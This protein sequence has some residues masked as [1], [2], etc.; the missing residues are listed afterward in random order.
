MTKDER[1]EIQKAIH[2]LE[3]LTMALGEYAVNLAVV[4]TAA[5]TLIDTQP[6]MGEFQREVK[7]K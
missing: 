3:P 4:L 7:I 1:A 6:T 2:F 5:Q